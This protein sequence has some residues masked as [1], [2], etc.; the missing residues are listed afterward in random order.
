MTLKLDAALHAALNA[1]PPL[2]FMRLVRQDRAT[3][4]NDARAALVAGQVPQFSFTKAQA[5]DLAPF[6]EALAA[7]G[8]R[9]HNLAPNETVATL[10]EAKADELAMRAALIGRMQQGDDHGVSIL[11]RTLYGIPSTL[12]AELDTHLAEMIASAGPRKTSAQVK[13]WVDAAMF[14]EMARLM[15]VH[16]GMSDA[17]VRVLKRRSIKVGR[18]RATH[19]LRLLV[20]TDLRITR[21]R[22]RQLLAHEIEAHALRH[23]N[24]IRSPLHILARGTAGY[25]IA[26]E[27]LAMT[28]QA[29]HAQGNHW[30]GFWESY[31]VAIALEHD[32]PTTFALLRDARAA[33]ATA[34]HDPNA[35]KTGEDAAWRLCL[36][37]YQGIAHPNRPG[38]AFPRDHVYLSGYHAVSALPNVNS[39]YIGKVA[40]E[41]VPALTALGITPQH[42]PD[43]ISKKIVSQVVRTIGTRENV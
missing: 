16:Y 34:M 33:L 6:H 13:Y 11:A 24:G 15:F 5:L 18:H 14:A 21:R 10:Y 17:R 40:I 30:P 39:L 2:P 35:R 9:I 43:H 28:L 38:L 3:A 42:T 23:L 4:L 36:R 37:I 31:A 25:L 29:E 27:G 12:R 19:A 32:G 26:D 7:F 22:A 1:L 41:D 20:P 8:N